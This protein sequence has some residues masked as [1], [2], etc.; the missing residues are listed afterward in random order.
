MRGV[1]TIRKDKKLNGKQATDAV[2]DDVQDNQSR[3]QVSALNLQ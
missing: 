3:T 2:Y 1:R